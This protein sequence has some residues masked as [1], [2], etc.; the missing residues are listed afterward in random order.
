MPF[1]VHAKPYR[2]GPGSIE[3]KGRREGKNHGLIIAHFLVV[4]VVVVVAREAKQRERKHA[5]HG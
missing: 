2:K 4:V 5:M 1:F 3:E